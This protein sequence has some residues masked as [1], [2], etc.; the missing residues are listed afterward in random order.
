MFNRRR[1]LSLPMVIGA[2]V[3]GIVS[4]KAIFGPPVDEYWKKKL[5]EEE[6]AA[7]GTDTNSS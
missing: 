6:A 1:F 5:E 2:V 4:G 3:I 7:K